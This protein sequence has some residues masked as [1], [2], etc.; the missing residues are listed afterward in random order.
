VHIQSLQLIAHAEDHWATFDGTPKPSYIAPWESIPD[1]EKE[2]VTEIYAQMQALVQAGAQDKQ[3]TRL[4]REQGGRVIRIA[5][6]GQVY[7]HVSDPKPSYVCNW[8]EMLSWEQEVD[9]D[10]FEK[11]QDKVLPSSQNNKY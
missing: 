9:M 1:W 6:I 8:E 7:K 11:M 3:V 2:I 4:N 5:W 10:I